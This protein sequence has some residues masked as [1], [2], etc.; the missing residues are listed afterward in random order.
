MERECCSSMLVALIGGTTLLVCGWWPVAD[1]GASSAWP[2]ERVT[3]RRLWLPVVPALTAAAWLCGWALAEPDPVPETVPISV[4]LM[5]LPFALLFDRRRWW[6][7][8][9][10]P[11]DG[12]RMAR[13]SEMG[14]EGEIVHTERDEGQSRSGRRASLIHLIFE[15]GVI[16]KGIDG[17]LELIGGLLLVAL[18]PAAIGG[19]I[20]YLVQ[21]ELKEDPTDLVANLLLHNTQTIIHTR[22]SASVFLIVH[23]V[24]KLGLVGGLVTNK[25]WS[26][27]AAIMMFTGFSIYQAYQLTQQNSLFLGIATVL[28][29]MVVLLVIVEYRHVR[30]ATKGDL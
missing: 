17:A 15:I 25:L 6:V 21:G 10:A 12:P 19:T 9:R 29:L 18:S 20:W 14:S 16:A 26:Y 1:S 30:L 24:V 22:V 7:A 28:D 11:S 3:W 23:G 2:F 5:S 8:P 13:S 4:I 27:P